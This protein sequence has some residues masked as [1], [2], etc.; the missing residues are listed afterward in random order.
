VGGGGGGLRLQIKKFKQNIYS[1]HVSMSD[2]FQK[3]YLRILRY[4][5]ICSLT[6][7]H[8]RRSQGRVIIVILKGT[9]TRIRELW[10]FSLI[11][12][13]DYQ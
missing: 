12:T 13:Y 4:G 7:T 2:I 10:I 6:R 3:S 11:K 1:D 5:V 9:L 8:N